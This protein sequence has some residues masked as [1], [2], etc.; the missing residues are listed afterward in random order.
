LRSIKGEKE[1]IN[2][3]QNLLYIAHELV[4][5]ICSTFTAFGC[6]FKCNKIFNI[7][8][9]VIKCFKL[10]TCKSKKKCLKDNPVQI[11]GNVVSLLTILFAGGITYLLLE[12]LVEE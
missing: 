7:N 1:K 5:F 10:V 4:I 9:Q 2:V 11:T 3:A 12:L 8:Y 6:G